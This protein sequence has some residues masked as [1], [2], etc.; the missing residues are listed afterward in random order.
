MLKASLNG[1][2]FV[3]LTGTLLASDPPL[4]GASS[5]SVS[6]RTASAQEGLDEGNLRLE[7]L[8]QH[9][10]L[11]PFIAYRNETQGEQFLSLVATDG[12][13]KEEV[14]ASDQG[15]VT[16]LATSD[17]DSLLLEP[18]ATVYLASQVELGQAFRN[19]CLVVTDDA[20]ACTA[21]GLWFQPLPA[22][23]A[24]IAPLE[25]TDLKAVK[26]SFNLWCQKRIPN[27]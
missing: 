5:L 15:M 13:E 24:R 22:G 10:D 26:K 1:A 18:G 25:G 17:Q 2:L 12:A 21:L 11:S 23:V 4:P 6:R 8:M 27:R 7:A 14:L 20:C 9:K 16:I 19:A 3:V